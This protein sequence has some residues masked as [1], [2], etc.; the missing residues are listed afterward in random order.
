MGSD[1]TNHFSGR[2]GA[3]SLSLTNHTPQFPVR[4]TGQTRIK[5]LVVKFVIIVE[6]LKGKK[7]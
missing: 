2:G 1:G 3:T 4:S 7:S 6:A 5:I